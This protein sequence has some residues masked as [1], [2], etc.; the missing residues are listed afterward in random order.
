MTPNHLVSPFKRSSFN[1]LNRP[2]LFNCSEKL[3][4][5]I[6]HPQTVDMQATLTGQV[7]VACIYDP[8][9]FASASEGEIQMTVFLQLRAPRDIPQIRLGLN[10]CGFIFSSASENIAYFGMCFHN[11]LLVATSHALNSPP[12][13]REPC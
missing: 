10:W 3:S 9:S 12:K 8:S 13:W 4:E 1:L 6:N 11:I 5:K 7:R 2:P